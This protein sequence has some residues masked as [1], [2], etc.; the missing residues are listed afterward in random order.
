MNAIK[1][2]DKRIIS[3]TVTRRDGRTEISISN[4]YEGE[5]NV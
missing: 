4:F 2:K 1:D 5:R 3:L